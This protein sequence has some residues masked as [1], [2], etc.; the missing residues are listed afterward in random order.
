MVVPVP[1]GPVWFLL[2]VPVTLIAPP[3]MPLIVL[4][5]LQRAWRKS[6]Q[7]PLDAASLNA[8]QLRFIG[9]N[10]GAILREKRRLLMVLVIC[11]YLIALG[12]SYILGAAMQSALDLY[13]AKAQASQALQ[14]ATPEQVQYSN[15]VM[16][17]IALYLL[18][19]VLTIVVI[20]ATTIIAL[21]TTPD[22]SGARVLEFER[23]VPAVITLLVKNLPGIAMILALMYGVLM[24]VERYYAHYRVIAVEAMVLGRTYFDPS[25]WF[26]LLR[27]YLVYAFLLSLVLVLIMGCGLLAQSHHSVKTPKPGKL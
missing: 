19:I 21:L 20:C 7:L 26:L 14:I 2:A 22:T 17:Y 18:A 25:I 1:R 13:I 11:Y 4:A 10:L 15:S 16:H 24:T 27:G 12:G 6:S 9:I 3:A 23:I 5:F 8:V